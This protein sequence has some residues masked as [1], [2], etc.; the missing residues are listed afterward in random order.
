MKTASEWFK[1]VEADFQKMIG[2]RLFTVMEIV[3]DGTEAQRI[4]TNDAA[5]Y[6]V[7]GRKPLNR[8][9]WYARVIVGQHCFLAMRP[10]DFRDVFFDHEKIVEMGLGSA[11][12]VPVM[13]EGRVRGTINLLDRTGA[14]QESMLQVCEQLAKGAA[15]NAFLAADNGLSR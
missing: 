13:V 14:Y 11:I 10:E 15:V 5:A 2:H 6:P 7:T 3:E 1:E 12:N 8:D 9:D 4:Y